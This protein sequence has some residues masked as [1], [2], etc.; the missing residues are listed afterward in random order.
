MIIKLT[1][2]GL[3]LVLIG[4]IVSS[5]YVNEEGFNDISN[6]YYMS[7]TKNLGGAINTVANSNA[8]SKSVADTK[9]AT[10][11]P[12]LM[13]DKM[14]TAMDTPAGK[15][16]DT[17]VIPKRTDVVPEVSLSGSG[18]DAMALQQRADLLKDIQKV[19]KNEIIASRNTTPL[20]GKKQ[21]D[22]DDTDSTAQGKEYEESCH[23]DTEYRCPKNP[24]G[25][26]PPIPDMS[27]YIKK[28]AIPCWGCNIDY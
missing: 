25:T 20:L 6:G 5:Y 24:N 10:T 22:K 14:P 23:K 21:S 9:S 8:S 26:C 2:V 7:I 4:V 16:L 27:D 11:P 1:L 18:Y 15:V 13:N 12:M 17:S 28:D 19:V 3:L